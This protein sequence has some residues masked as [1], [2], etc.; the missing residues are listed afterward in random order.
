MIS[1]YFKFLPFLFFLILIIFP[2]FGDAVGGMA[3]M[4]A[5]TG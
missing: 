1:K 4:K 3:E 5:L 2:H